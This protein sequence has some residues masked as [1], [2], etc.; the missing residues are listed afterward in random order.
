MSKMHRSNICRIVAVLF[1]VPLL[2]ACEK[3]EPSDNPVVPEGMVE[4]RPV[5]GS[6]FTSIPRDPA[7]TGQPGTRVYD[8]N[9]TT[10]G[11]LTKTHR[12]PKGSTVWLIAG[13]T[14]DGGQ[15]ISGA[16][17]KRSYVVYNP[18]DAPDVSY[19]VPCTVDD[20]GN[21][22]DMDGSPFYLKDNQD[23]M[24]YGIS[25]ARKL[26]E[27]KFA[28]Q[29][30]AFQVKNG[31]AFYA[32]DSRYSA[33]TPQHVTVTGDDNAEALQIVSLCPMVNQTAQIKIQVQKGDGVHDLDIQPSGIQVS[34][35]QNDSPQPAN[36]YGDSNGLYWHMSRSRAD[37]P[38]VLQHGSKTGV[39]HSYDYEIDENGRVNIEVPVL[40]MRSLSKPVI[41]LLRLKINGVPT[42]YELML[43]EKDFK[44]GY[45]YGYRG[46]VSISDGIDVVTWQ[47]VSWDYDLAFPF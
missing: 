29:E 20:E 32:N 14:I 8:S 17:E 9:E 15:T 39:Y 7:D 21:M 36:E 12:L 34:G 43:N 26:D 35:L 37:E 42:S 10:D 44:A 3:Q 16:L 1:L 22:L 18:E 24:F 5:L 25:P 19:L 6:V 30:I 13:R 46:Q 28:T 2:A 38:I 31:E 45:S 47:Y 40:P 4:I 27:K 23:Y 33:T 41:V 11:K